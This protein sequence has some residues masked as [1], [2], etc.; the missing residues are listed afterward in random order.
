M[1]EKLSEPYG[2]LYYGSPDG[3]LFRRDHPEGLYWLCVSSAPVYSHEQMRAAVAAADALRRE[4]DEA[5]RDRDMLRLC[6]ND[7][8]PDHAEDARGMV[9]ERTEPADGCGACGDMQKNIQYL[10][11]LR[12]GWSTHAA[13]L[14]QRVADLEAL[15]AELRR[16]RADLAAKYDELRDGQGIDTTSGRAWMAA[17]AW[18]GESLESD[19]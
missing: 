6:M 1:S 9:S 11:G 14:A 16:A 7:A 2:W 15:V 18:A 10:E 3:P 8:A 19:E 13:D 12:Q 4:R 17:F 5:R